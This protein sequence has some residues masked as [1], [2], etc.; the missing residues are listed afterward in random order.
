MANIDCKRKRSQQLKFKTVAPN[1]WHFLFVWFE[2]QGKGLCILPAYCDIVRAA[3]CRINS[4]Q[5]L[6]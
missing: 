6:K 3:P 4:G 1:I 5:K 2:K